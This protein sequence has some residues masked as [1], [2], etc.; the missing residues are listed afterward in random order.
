MRKIAGLTQQQLAERIGVSKVAI[1]KIENDIN[2]MHGPIAHKIGNELGC[3]MIGGTDAKSHFRWR[4]DRKGSREDLTSTKPY[5]REDFKIAED[6]RKDDCTEQMANNCVAA[7]SSS[8]GMLIQG[9]T[10]A[11]RLRALMED[12]EAAMLGWF[13]SYNLESPI[14]GWLKDGGYDSKGTKHLLEVF[15]MSPGL[16]GFEYNNPDEVA[17]IPAEE[18]ARSSGMPRA[19]LKEMEELIASAPR[20]TP[21]DSDPP[22]FNPYINISG[23]SLDFRLKHG[24]WPDPVEFEREIYQSYRA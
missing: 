1:Q 15:E 12:I 4:L 17:S 24:V 9:A 16:A 23:K 7:L 18:Y 3:S 8:L 2:E 6:S 22:G 13:Y 20:P 10:R 14:S 11:R 5:T 21:L 19:V